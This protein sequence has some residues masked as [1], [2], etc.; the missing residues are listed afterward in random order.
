M[1]YRDT[2][3][4]RR[5]GRVPGRW[6][7]LVMAGRR[8]PRIL[9][10]RLSDSDLLDHVVSGLI[11]LGQAMSIGGFA[12]PVPLRY[13]HSPRPVELTADERRTWRELVSLLRVPD[14]AG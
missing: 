7:R 12:P 4:S 10:R 1:A 14:H 2:P 9:A 13:P 6:R 5:A 11:L 8:G 3:A